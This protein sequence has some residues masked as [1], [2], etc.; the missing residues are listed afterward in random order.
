MA[1]KSAHHISDGAKYLAGLARRR[2]RHAN[3]SPSAHGLSTR[4]RQAY[5]MPTLS[6]LPVVTL[7]AVYLTDFYEAL[8]ARLSALS[9]YIALARSLDV[10]SDPLMSYLTDS[11][12]SRWGRRRP[13]CVTGCWFYA[14]FLMA[15]LNPPDLSATTMGN[16][17]GLFY[18]LFFLANTYTTIPYDALGPELTDNYEDRSRLFF[19]SGLYDG[20][21]AL[22]AIT[23]PQFF[24]QA[25]DLYYTGCDYSTCYDDS[26]V[27][28]DCLP[29]I[30][31]QIYDTYDLGFSTS[32]T[33]ATSTDDIYEAETCV[34][35][36]TLSA[37]LV[38][39]C[40]CRATCATRCD[41]ESQRVAFEAVG[42]FF[43]AWFCATMVSMFFNVKERSHALV[44]AAA[45]ETP[46]PTADKAAVGDVA[47]AVAGPPRVRAGPCAFP[48]EHLPQPPLRA[49]PSSVDM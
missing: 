14:A 37:G 28:T 12:R 18:I 42:F 1:T 46:S 39:Y 41:L 17:F 4:V 22:I 45:G 20:I 25:A 6:T 34:T 30:N 16:Y 3:L 5:C 38:E 44:P 48:A 47:A 33:T 29:D 32:G 27:G 31:T 24:A 26:G 8:G 7:L 43:G 19:V 9:F 2:K 10:T 35:N 36:S 49:A 15:L 23:L 40:A 11:C 21:G 13:F